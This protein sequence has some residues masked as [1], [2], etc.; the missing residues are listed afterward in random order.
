MATLISKFGS[1]TTASF[2]TTG[3][4]GTI[5]LTETA[6]NF[7][8]IDIFFKGNNGYYDFTRVYNP[9]GKTVN[10][11]TMESTTGSIKCK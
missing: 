10:L 11:A 7:T 5:T 9:N 4:N 2:N 8:I 3:S 6:A 1:N